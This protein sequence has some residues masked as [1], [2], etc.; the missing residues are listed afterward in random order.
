MPFSITPD[1]QH[2][3]AAASKSGRASFEIVDRKGDVRIPVAY[4][5]QG[6]AASREEAEYIT[7]NVKDL[8]NGMPQR[9]RFGKPG[10][11]MH[12]NIEA[13]NVTFTFHERAEDGQSRGNSQ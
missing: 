12:Y 9:R 6:E 7:E 1:H 4:L 5:F 10:R 8:M 11:T 2:P 13:S 3:F